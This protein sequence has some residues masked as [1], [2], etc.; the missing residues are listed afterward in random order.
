MIPGVT[1]RAAEAQDEAFLFQLFKAVRGPDFAR[2][3][4]APEQFD[5]LLNMQYMGQK[6]TYGAQYPGGNQVVILDGSPIGRIWLHRAEGEHELVDIALLPEFR[7]RG[8]GTALV[9]EAISASR[10][11]GVPLRCSVDIA[12]PGSLR[13]HRR[14]GFQIVSQDEVQYQLAVE[15]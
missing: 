13:F 6:M 11:A 4:M 2:I 8:I 12:N 3:P 7:N 9:T 14:L 15:P 10:A 1:T 5:M